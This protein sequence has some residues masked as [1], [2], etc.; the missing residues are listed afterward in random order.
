VTIEQ[1][2][3]TIEQNVGTIEQKGGANKKSTK[4]SQISATKLRP[5]CNFSSNRFNK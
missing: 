2:V 5:Y 3:V 1:T 4:K